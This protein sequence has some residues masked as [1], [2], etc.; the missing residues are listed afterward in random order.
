MIICF[1]FILL[2]WK[3]DNIFNFM[4]LDKIVEYF[5]G[6]RNIDMIRKNWDF[7]GYNKIFLNLIWLFCIWL[8]VLFLFNFSVRNKKSGEIRFV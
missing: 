5:I 7:G 1:L 4:F 8:F 3:S 6:F 2:E